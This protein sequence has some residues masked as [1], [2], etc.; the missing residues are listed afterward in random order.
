M[1]L[2]D[3]ACKN[4]HKNDKAGSGKP[5]KLSDEKGLFLLLQPQED[6]WG[7]WWRFKYRFE[8][9]EKLLSLGTYPETSLAQAREKRDEARKQIAAGIDPGENRKAVKA[10]K[11]ESAANS[12]EVIAREWGLKKV[13]N[14]EEKNHRSK[15]MLERNVFPW[16]GGKPIAEI[17]PKD[18]LAC[19]RRVEDN[20]TIETAHRTLQICGQVFRYAVATGRADRDITHDLKGALPP[21][22]GEHFAAITEPKEAAELLRAIDGYQGSLPAVCALKLAPLVFVRPGEL[23]AMQWQDVN[24]DTAEWRFFITKTKV[25]HIVPLSRQ[26]VA[27]LQ[28]LFPLT[29]RGRYAFPSERTPNGDRCMSENTIN[30]ALKRLGYGKDKMTGHGF[31][32]MARTILDEVL[33]VRPDFIE[34]QLA[35]AVRDPNGRA[36][37]RTAH[38]SERHKMM[39]QWADYLDALKAGEL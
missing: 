4:A 22:K 19:L 9:K 36:Y 3:T 10:A 38:L 21:A 6:G 17:L 1:P 27:I 12:F 29:G 32:A 14:W 24:L 28:D 30:A 35:H 39:Q 34:H 2:S 5:F 18:I 8:G 7:K 23:R 20:G 26:A 13:D 25:Q 15:R 11:A 31:R 37:N 33:G 16:L